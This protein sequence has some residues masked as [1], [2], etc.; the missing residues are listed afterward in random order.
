M[1]TSREGHYKGVRKRP[2]GR[3]TAEI[4]DPWKKTRVWLAQHHHRLAL[5]EFL[6][7]WLLKEININADSSSPPKPNVVTVLTA[8]PVPRNMSIALFLRIIRRGLPMDLNEPPPL[9]L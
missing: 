7:T 3:Y 2:W 6:Q 9:W 4:R 8:P 1:A 5:H